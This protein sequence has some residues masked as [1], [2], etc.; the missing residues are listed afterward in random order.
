MRAVL[1]RK[2]DGAARGTSRTIETPIHIL[3]RLRADEITPRCVESGNSSHLPL[4]I[5]DTVVYTVSYIPPA[6]RIVRGTHLSEYRALLT[7][8]QLLMLRQSDNPFLNGVFNQFTAVVHPQ[9]FHDV[10]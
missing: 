8:T 5:K 2:S 1:H 3:V 7:C 10:R 4:Q 9:F 6:N